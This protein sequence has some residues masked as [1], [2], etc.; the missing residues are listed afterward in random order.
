MGLDCTSNQCQATTRLLL[1]DQYVEFS[2]D[3]TSVTISNIPYQNCS[4]ILGDIKVYGYESNNKI[5]K[6]FPKNE[7]ICSGSDE[8]T[9]LYEYLPTPTTTEPITTDSTT[10]TNEA[11]KL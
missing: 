6:Y 5:S 2:A 10:V 11:V 7:N 8:V 4:Y 3:E 1:N 9:V